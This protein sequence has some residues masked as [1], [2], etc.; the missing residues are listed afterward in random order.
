MA[1]YCACYPPCRCEDELLAVADARCLGLLLLHLQILYELEHS[2]CVRSAFQAMF[3][4][5]AAVFMAHVG[6]GLLVERK[7][8]TSRLASLPD[9][10]EVTCDFC[11]QARTSVRGCPLGDCMR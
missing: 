3:Y 11:G 9:Q 6:C 2:T 4:L 7:Q 5:L 1:M 10:L 8:T